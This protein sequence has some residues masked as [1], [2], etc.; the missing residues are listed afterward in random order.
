[1]CRRGIRD[2]EIGRK[3]IGYQDDQR[4]RIGKCG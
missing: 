2:Q 3:W 4:G 1:M